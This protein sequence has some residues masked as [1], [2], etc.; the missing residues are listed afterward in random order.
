[1][2]VSSEPAPGQ[3]TL[4]LQPE[5]ILATNQ[6]KQISTSRASTDSDLEAF[7]RNPTD[8][9]VAALAVQPTAHAKDLTQRFLS[10]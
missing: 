8:V 5:L 10:Y 7:S 3:T 9:S 4:G 1:M 2:L 6:T